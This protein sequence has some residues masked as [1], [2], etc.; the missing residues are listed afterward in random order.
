MQNE[1]HVL[2]I[3]TRSD[4]VN[5]YGHNAGFFILDQDDQSE[6]I[7]PKSCATISFKYHFVSSEA[8]AW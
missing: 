1:T 3:E 4:G 7:T 2:K 5:A 8:T 6:T